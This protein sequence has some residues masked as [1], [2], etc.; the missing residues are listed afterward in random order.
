MY[1]GVSR[2]VVL[3]HAYR[4]QQTN[5]PVPCIQGLVD[6]LSCPMGTG[7]SEHI[8]SAM[9]HSVTQSLQT[10]IQVSIREV[11]VVSVSGYAVSLSQVVV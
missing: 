6:R 11:P 10:N 1:T 5:C 4:G 7:V 9:Q 8:I 2:Q 3:S